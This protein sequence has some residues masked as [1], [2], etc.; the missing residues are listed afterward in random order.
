MTRK[1]VIPMRTEA[2]DF[3]CSYYL[4][5]AQ[6]CSVMA[7]F[8]IYRGPQDKEQCWGCRLIGNSGKPMAESKDLHMKKDIGDA[9][10]NLRNCAADSDTDA[11]SGALNLLNVSESGEGKHLED[12]CKEM[13]EA[14]ITWENE[15][16]D[17]AH[18]SKNDDSTETKGI[19]GS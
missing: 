6:R 7:K 4:L 16:D 2:L 9:M 14:E 10:K 11:L 3:K 17:P 12:I 8:Q 5:K 18:Q 15:K 13:K 1:N 19:P